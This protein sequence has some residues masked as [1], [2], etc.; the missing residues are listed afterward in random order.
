MRR[1]P[2]SDLQSLI[3]VIALYHRLRPRIVHHVT[4]KP[5]LYGTIAARLSGIPAVINAMTG[6]GE[7]FA[8]SSFS[9]R[10]WRA[11]VI[12]LFRLFVRHPRMRVIV[13]NDDDRRLLADAGAVSPEIMVL[14]RGSG[15]DPDFFQGAEPPP[16]QIPTV[17]YASRIM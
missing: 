4:F 15:V 1:K 12:A 9:D 2:W 8:A 16:S 13:Q 5:V 3:S 6:L 14:I 7:I 10:I 17:V 11:I